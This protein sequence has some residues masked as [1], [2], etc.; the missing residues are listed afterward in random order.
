MKPQ[1]V[2]RP[3]ADA[4]LDEQAIFIAQ[5]NIEAALRFLQAAET[6]FSNLAQTPEMGR[7]WRS[8]HPHLS[9]VRIWR[10]KGFEKWL[11]FYRPTTKG[12]EILHIFHGARNIESLL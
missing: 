9:D 11:V 6:T 2:I 8:N 12:I 10:V 4:E 1:I 5:D 7:L 3:D